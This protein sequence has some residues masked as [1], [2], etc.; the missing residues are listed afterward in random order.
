MKNVVFKSLGCFFILVVLSACGGGG[1]DSSPVFNPGPPIGTQNTSPVVPVTPVVLSTPAV[2]TVTA[3]SYVVG[4]PEKEAYDYLNA[5]L[6]RCGFGLKQEKPSLNIAAQGHADWQLVN[7][8]SSHFQLNSTPGFTGVDPYDRIANAGYGARN[9]FVGADEISISNGTDDKNI[10]AGRESIARLLNAPHHLRGLVEGFKDIG[11]SIRNSQDAQSKHGA[12]VVAQINMGYKL[13][14]GYQRRAKKFVT[15]PCDGS[16]GVARSLTNESPEP[17]IG[18]NLANKPLGT[19]M[20][21][22][23]N[24]GDKIEVHSAK[25]TEFVSGEVVVT[26]EP[27][28]KTNTASALWSYGEHE[29]YVAADAPLKPLTLYK[30]VIEYSLN[31]VL[32]APETQ[33]FTTG[34]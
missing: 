14:E 26:R 23:A 24:V 31:G 15:Y 3:A 6:G 34:N 20:Y 32:Q 1:G 18:R 16:V 30:M 25:M 19:S 9:S 29:T 2:T 28:S 22:G 4:S 17:V 5:E 21:M 27:V 10:Y 33:T 7:N 12:R 11:I 13:S 8:Y